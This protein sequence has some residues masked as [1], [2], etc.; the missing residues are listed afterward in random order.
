MKAQ[1]IS[2]GVEIE[3]YIPVTHS[4]EFP[5]GSYHNGVQISIAPAGWNG[6]ADSSLGAGFVRDGVQYRPVEV[7]SPKLKGE[8]GLEQVVYMVD[9]LNEIGAIV[10][11]A[12]G[13]HVHV[14]ARKLTVG[15]VELVKKAFVK[16]EKAFYG[17][18]GEAA[19]DR[20]N[21]RY[22]KPSWAWGGD[23]DRYQ[24]LNVSNY[25]RYD[26]KKTVEVRVWQAT[27]DAV[28][29]VAAVYMAVALVAKVT[30]GQIEEGEALE[31]AEQAARA[32]VRSHFYGKQEYRIIPDC[33]I[34]DLTQV[35]FKQ[36]KRARI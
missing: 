4:G 33:D 29:V 13:L 16:Y 1:N 27:T 17:L 32:F 14:D 28:I 10:T 35:L 34:A 11:D 19:S 6:Q 8:S 26:K 15:Q 5:T 9:Y 12:C 31:T 2:F 30:E 25:H 21:S 20:I 36:T 7:V 3:C 23:Y 22:T 24:S 18:S